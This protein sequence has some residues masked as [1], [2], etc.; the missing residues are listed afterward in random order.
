VF[1]LLAALMAYAAAMAGVIVVV[2]V[3]CGVLY[4][5]VLAVEATDPPEVKAKRQAEASETKRV[6]RQ[7]EESRRVR[8]ARRD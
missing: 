1:V 8:L 2:I 3:F 6:L 7:V 4:L 5:I